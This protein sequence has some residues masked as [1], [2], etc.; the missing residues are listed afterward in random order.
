MGNEVFEKSNSFDKG[1]PYHIYHISTSKQIFYTHGSTTIF[2]RSNEILWQYALKPNIRAMLTNN[3]RRFG[4][5][6]L[7]LISDYTRYMIQCMLV[8]TERSKSNITIF[9]SEWLK[10]YS[11]N[12]ECCCSKVR[13]VK[14][15]D[16]YHEGVIQFYQPLQND[17][18][19]LPPTSYIWTACQMP[20][21]MQIHDCEWDSSV[22]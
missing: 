19:S 22:K 15:S 14:F 13:Y 11:I 7:D 21:K 12:L 18:I 4:G 6:S 16:Y 8:T 10:K 17:D 9:I 3:K 20:S 1:D 2:G 5:D